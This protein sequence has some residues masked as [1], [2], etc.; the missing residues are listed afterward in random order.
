MEINTPDE[1]EELESDIKNNW[2]KITM[3]L[4][5]VLAVVMVFYTLYLKQVLH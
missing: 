1:L 4:V 5:G 2:A 3:I